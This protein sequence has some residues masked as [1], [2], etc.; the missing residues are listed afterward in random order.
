MMDGEAITTES[1]EDTEQEELD[2]RTEEVMGEVRDRLDQHFMP[3]EATVL[4][5]RLV[6]FSLWHWRTLMAFRSPA[7]PAEGNGLAE[8][9]DLYLAARIC[10]GAPFG[11]LDCLRVGRFAR[12]QLTWLQLRMGDDWL[13]HEEVWH[14][15]L[16]HHLKGPALFHGENS[17]TVGSNTALY[18]AAGL[19]G[20]GFSERDA[21]CCTPGMARHYLAAYREACGDEVAFMSSSAV[22]DAIAAGYTKEE[23][24]G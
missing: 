20:M 24:L 17:R 12:L 14:R 21:W 13:V 2:A 8:L 16:D 22:R 15:Y 6:P 23:I 4:G 18:L 19:I 5:M 1:T 11:S 3:V 10:S 7:L 9:Q